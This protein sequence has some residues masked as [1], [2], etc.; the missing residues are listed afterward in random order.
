MGVKGLRATA[1]PLGESGGMC[2]RKSLNLRPSEITSGTFSD[3]YIHY[4]QLP[5]E[6]KWLTNVQGGANAP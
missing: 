1:C 5:L 3:H 6:K 2:S 4:I